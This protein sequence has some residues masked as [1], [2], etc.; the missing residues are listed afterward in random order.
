MSIYISEFSSS[1]FTEKVGLQIS[2]NSL[3]ILSL[4]ADALFDNIMIVLRNSTKIIIQEVLSRIKTS[5]L[6]LKVPKLKDGEYYLSLYYNSAERK[7]YYEAYIYGNS[8]TIHALNNV[9]YFKMPDVAEHNKQFLDNICIDNHCKSQYTKPSYSIQSYDSDIKQKAREITK[10]SHTNYHRLLSIHNWAARNL[11]YDYDSLI[12]ESYK[13][14]KISATDVLHSGKSVCQG[15]TEL[16]IALIR[17]LNIPAIGITCYASN[18]NS[19]GMYA[20]PKIQNE[21]NHIFTAAYID[22]KWVLMDCTW[23]SPN[24]YEK[25]SFCKMNTNGIFTKY[26]DP[27]LQFISSTHCFVDIYV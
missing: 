5:R 10:F 9:L 15:Y 12:D 24:R 3:T 26:F 1:H 11:F 13:N 23:D 25:N 19:I 8:I 27:T 14:S 17:S 6:S 20:P 21:A 16:T 7:E 18:N 2:L 22:N 4:P